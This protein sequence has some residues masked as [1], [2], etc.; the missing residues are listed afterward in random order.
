MTT[1]A[2]SSS[3]TYTPGFA[4]CKMLMIAYGLLLMTAGFS[5]LW[6]PLRLLTFGVPAHAEATRVIKSKGGLPDVILTTDAKI[7]SQLEPRDRSYLF[8]NEFKFQ[9]A[10]GQTIQV[11]API[12]SLLKPLFALND[13]DGL[14][15]TNLV[16][17]DRSNPASVTFPCIA[18]T[19]F[20]PGVVF[21]IGLVGVLIGSTL[22]YWANKPIELPHI[23]TAPE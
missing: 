10:Q 11:R 17:Y 4:R 15:T 21:V 9:T 12:A 7:Q 18:S 8:W 13:S 19:W 3:G 20:G 2:S 5:Q 1:N 6:T 16:Y 14:P 22:L 23:G